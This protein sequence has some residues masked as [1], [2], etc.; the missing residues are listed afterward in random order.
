[1]REQ[2]EYVYVGEPVPPMPEREYAAFYL[3]YQTA[4]LLSLQKRGLLTEEQTARCIAALEKQG[5]KKA[6]A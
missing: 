2:Q 6:I 3:R 5:R 4:I 1:M